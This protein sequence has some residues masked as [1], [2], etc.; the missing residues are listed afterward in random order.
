MGRVVDHDGRTGRTVPKAICR[1][2]CEHVICRSFVPLATGD[3]VRVCRKRLCAGCLTG[4]SST[5]LYRMPP[6]NLLAE[7]VIKSDHAMHLSARQVERFRDGR[8]RSCGDVSELLLHFM[9]DRQKGTRARL[10]VENRFFYCC[11]CFWY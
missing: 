5:D 8:Y 7:M 4:L 2:E 9:Q 6:R 11:R 3:L 10:I 1:L